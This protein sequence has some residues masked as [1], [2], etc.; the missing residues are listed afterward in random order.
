LHLPGTAIRA[1]LHKNEKA[2]LQ[3]EHGNPGFCSVVLQA[4]DCH[5][6]FV[7]THGERGGPI[8][9]ISHGPQH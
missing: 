5:A 8:K 4:G 7:M 6:L 9:L 3:A 1:K 2:S